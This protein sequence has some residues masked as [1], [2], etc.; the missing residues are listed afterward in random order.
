MALEDSP[1]IGIHHDAYLTS[2]RLDAESRAVVGALYE[3]TGQLIPASQRDIGRRDR[4][5]LGDPE[6]VQKHDAVGKYQAV[7]RPVETGAD[8]Y[9]EKA[10][11]AGHLMHGWGH[12]ITESLSTAWASDQLPNCPVVFTPW[13]R[14]PTRSLSR[15]FE[16]LRLGGWGKREIVLA[17]ADCIF[18][19]VYVPQRL[20]RLDDCIYNRQPIHP[21][22]N[23]PYDRMVEASAG[24]NEQVP[25]L[26]ARPEGHRRGH[27]M[28][29]E[30]TH[31]LAG[32]GVRIIKGWELSVERQVAVAN[33]A[34]VLIGFSGSNL[35]NSVFARRGIRIIEVQDARAHHVEHTLQSALCELRDQQ[36]VRI[37]GFDGNEPRDAK[38]IVTDIAAALEG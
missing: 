3:A 29:P 22:Q 7:P 33:A 10:I 11:F 12:L 20:V 24:P 19:T 18:G 36:L 35:H 38:S 5:R 34:S 16:A 27:P 8:L 4:W 2:H 14:V 26:L 31:V 1:T 32:L 23:V 9:L 37:P 6:T 25:T 28:E 21:A 17:S 13:A 15:R 30:I